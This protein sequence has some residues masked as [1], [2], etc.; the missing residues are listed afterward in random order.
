MRVQIRTASN[1][2]LGLANRD[3][4]IGAEN[5]LLFTEVRTLRRLSSVL[6]PHGLKARHYYIASPK[7]ERLGQGS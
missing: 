7:I 1:L 2:A 6:C 3:G 5:F 4:F